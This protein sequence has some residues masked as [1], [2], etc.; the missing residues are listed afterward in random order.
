MVTRHKGARGMGRRW[1]KGTSFLYTMNK[2]WGITIQHGDIVNTALYTS[3]SGKEFL[4][5][6]STKKERV[7]MRCDA[8][9]S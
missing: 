8:S 6:L 5:I 2:I 3:K 1:S 7:I 9:V 4:N